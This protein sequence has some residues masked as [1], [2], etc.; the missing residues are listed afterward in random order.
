MPV[1]SEAP[2][3]TSRRTTSSAR[4]VVQ[5]VPAALGLLGD[6]LAEL[7]WFVRD[8]TYLPREIQGI[9]VDVGA[10]HSPHFRAH[11]LVDKF[12]DDGSHRI[13]KPIVRR[14][15]QSLLVWADVEKLPIKDK[16]VAFTI[17]SHLLEHLRHP[18][19]ALDELV[20]VGHAGYVECPA[21]W[22]ETLF[23]YDPHLWYVTQENG[24]L[25]FAPKL[26]NRDRYLEEVFVPE[27]GRKRAIR[28]LFRNRA[29]WTVRMVWTGRCAYSVTGEPDHVPDFAQASARRGLADVLA[30]LISGAVGRFVRPSSVSEEA[31]M[32][33]FCCPE[34]KGDL[35]RGKASLVCSSCRRQ[36]P[37]QNR[38]IDFEH[39]TLL[40]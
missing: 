21:R 32:S 38:T 30:K 26:N 20:R 11:I 23:P 6:H 18:G 13:G 14:H 24:R 8:K 15:R 35:D 28:H 25:V 12:P 1:C 3:R 33:V 39:P 31:L 22:S 17:A 2:Q 27:L 34:C 40:A 7:K 16:G 9:V 29:F 36:Y 4:G 37:H 10:G 19:R 5:T